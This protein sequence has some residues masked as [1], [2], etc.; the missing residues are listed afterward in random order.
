MS[1]FYLETKQSLP[2][3][4]DVGHRLPHEVVDGLDLSFQVKSRG[5]V[6]L[7]SRSG[8]SA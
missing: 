5:R 2:L 3:L 7:T 1:P 4:C 6:P 8:W